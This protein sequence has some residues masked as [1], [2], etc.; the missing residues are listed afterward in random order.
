MSLEPTPSQTVGPYF[1]IGLGVPQNELVAADDPNAVRLTGQVLDGAGACVPDALVEIW[2]ASAGWGRC[3]TDA[4]GRYE[5]T[6]TRPGPVALIVFA[7]GLLKPVLTRVSFPSEA[8]GDPILSAIEDEAL[9]AT[10]VAAER[11]G[12]LEFDVRLQGDDQTAF[13]VL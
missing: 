11:D 5:F 10:L 7:R 13:F 1:T 8:D 12:A 2:Q 4:D 3:A 6:A 9:R